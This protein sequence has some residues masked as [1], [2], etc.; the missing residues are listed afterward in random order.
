MKSITVEL[1]NDEYIITVGMSIIYTMVEMI[2]FAY[3]G[4]E[5]PPQ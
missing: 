3:I 2:F 5:H 1:M 4:K